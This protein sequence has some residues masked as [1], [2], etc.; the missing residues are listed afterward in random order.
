MTT[1]TCDEIKNYWSS[2]FTPLTCFH[3]VDRDSFIFCFENEVIH[4]A[5]IK[6]GIFVP[7]PS[8]LAETY[9]FAKPNDVGGFLISPGNFEGWRYIPMPIPS[10][11]VLL[12]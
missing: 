3:D 5:T 1:I 12:H 10:A 8:L 4:G 7:P 11:A 6:A 2:V 9:L